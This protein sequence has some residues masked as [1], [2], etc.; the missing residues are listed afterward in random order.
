MHLNT[1]RILLLLALPLTATVTAAPA[2]APEKVANLAA[3]AAMAEPAAP[4]PAA[5]PAPPAAVA[6]PAA[7]APA[8]DTVAQAAEVMQVIASQKVISLSDPVV[9]RRMLN[10]MLSVVGGGAR[11][12]PQL[13]AGK[14]AADTGIGET[15]SL[16]GTML[17]VPLYAASP[18]AATALE[19][20]LAEARK[21]PCDG[22]VLDMR[23]AAGGTDAG[24]TRILALVQDQKLPLVVLV[25]DQT[26]G[27]PE[28]LAVL[29][30]TKQGITLVGG[31][32]RGAYSFLR[33]HRLSRGGVLLLPEPVTEFAG[34]P[35]PRGPLKPDIDGEVQPTR[36]TV[37]SL[38]AE[39]F[40]TFPERD[41]SL[42]KAVDLLVIATAL[43][44]RKF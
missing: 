6:A 29:L 9:A 40:E 43:K 13:S 41:R 12:L 21:L 30:K 37:A 23:H 34:V 8:V 44:E 19:A 31:P 2:S 42:L 7:P 27:A 28:V 38:T 10:A 4:A 32:T 39:R 17:F 20:A 14:A 3:P 22:L 26:A 15:V 18:E 11:Y 35:M 36:D 1:A 24:V 5:L 25:S 33:E 16:R